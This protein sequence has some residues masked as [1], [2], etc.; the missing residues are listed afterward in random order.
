MSISDFWSE[1]SQKYIL[2]KTSTLYTKEKMS[3]PQV[4]SEGLSSWLREE[5]NTHQKANGGRSSVSRVAAEGAEANEELGG[6]GHASETIFTTAAQN[7]KL[8]VCHV[9]LKT[10]TVLCATGTETES[11][12]KA[13]A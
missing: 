8:G 11:M 13:P 10:S 6:R 2:T 4:F 9:Q 3:L 7:E 1:H 12:G 5:E